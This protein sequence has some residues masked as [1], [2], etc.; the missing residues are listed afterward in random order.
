MYNSFMT[1]T[2]FDNSVLRRM[3]GPDNRNLQPDVAGFFLGLSLT[4]SD[5]QR[6][7]E[8]SGKANDGLLTAGERG[9]LGMYVL[10][11]DFIAIM[12]SKARASL[13]NRSP[14]A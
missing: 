5:N 4:D 12:Q 13:T 9:E 10:L 2:A 14:A 6:I 3:L 8:L 11:A 7:A 1:T